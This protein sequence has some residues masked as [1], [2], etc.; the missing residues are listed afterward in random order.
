MR[1]DT[2]LGK[3]LPPFSKTAAYLQEMAWRRV[4]TSLDKLL[5]TIDGKTLYLQPVLD[6]CNIL[7]HLDLYSHLVSPVIS[8]SFSCTMQMAIVAAR[9]PTRQC[10][11]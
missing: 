8:L 6:A 5:I 1:P 4:W 7:V 2:R 3:P 10:V 11:Y 9:S